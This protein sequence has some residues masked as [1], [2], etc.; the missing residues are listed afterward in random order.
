MAAPLARALRGALLLVAAAPASAQ[1]PVTELIERTSP[2]V[3]S[4]EVLFKK[5]NSAGRKAL[6]SPD[7]VRIER[8]GS[9]IFVSASGLV[10]TNAHLVEE[11]REG[12]DEYWLRIGLGWG[13]R[14]AEVLFRDEVADLALLQAKLLPNDEIVALPLASSAD[15]LSGSRVL[16][17]GSPAGEQGGA[18]AG[19]LAFT[20]G[21]V[22]LREA[23]LEPWQALLSDCRFHETLDGGPLLN[24]KGEL[25]G[26]HNSSHL[27]PLPESWGEDEEDEEEK[28]PDTDYA[29]IVSSDA[30]RASI[31]AHLEAAEREREQRERVRIYRETARRTRQKRE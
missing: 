6:N 8:P 16:A 9:G 23:L 21:P 15:Q 20:S 7:A 13:F 18:F 4:V 2:A 11:V 24:A 25:V 29:V 1:T 26:I 19:A 22:Q 28:K 27:N 14:D 5:V 12:S 17:I 31:G 3:V 30:I 10:L